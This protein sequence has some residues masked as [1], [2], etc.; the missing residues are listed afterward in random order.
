MKKIIK[1]SGKD[2]TMQSSAYTQ[3]KYKNDTGRKLMQDI[4]KLTK[5]RANDKND[6][7]NDLDDFLEIILQIT[8]IMIEEADSKQVGSFDEF[9]KTTD[10]LFEDN[11]WI[12]EVIELAMTPISRGFK[13]NPQ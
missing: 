2:Y 5:M 9:L 7:L 4:N 6:I 12:D 11:K 13:G 3:F 1:I 10:N 8:H